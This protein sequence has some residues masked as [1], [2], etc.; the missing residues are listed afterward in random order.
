MEDE[1][2]LNIAL[3]RMDRAEQLEC[4]ANIGD[5]QGQEKG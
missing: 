3:G 1:A 5:C 2:R 4:L